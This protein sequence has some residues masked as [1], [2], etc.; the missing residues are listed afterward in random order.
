[1]PM[2]M[3]LLA[4]AAPARLSAAVVWETAVAR[5][6]LLAG[7]AVALGGLAGRGL[8][9]QYKGTFPRPLPARGRCAARWPGW[10]AA[11]GWR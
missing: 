4:H 7:L 1:M 8:A 5:W 9:R 11:G 2:T 3:T 10:W 6:L